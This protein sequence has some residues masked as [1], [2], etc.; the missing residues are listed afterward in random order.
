MSQPLDRMD[1]LGIEVQA[2]H[3]VLPAEKETDQPFVIDVTLWGDF[4]KAQKDDDLAAALDYSLLHGRI[5]EAVVSS[6]F[7]LIE[8]LAGHLCHIV[9]A[10][11]SVAEVSLTVKKVHPPIADFKGTAAVTLR[12]GQTWLAAVT[13]QGKL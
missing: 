13:R 4:E 11:F 2:R 1:L 12:R 8:A 9:L 3:G 10:E 6:S 7:D 5:V